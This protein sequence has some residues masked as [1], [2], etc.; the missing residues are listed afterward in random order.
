MSTVRV[1]TPEKSIIN[2]VL[3]LIFSL[4]EDVGLER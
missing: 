3:H 1:Q 4:A 2:S